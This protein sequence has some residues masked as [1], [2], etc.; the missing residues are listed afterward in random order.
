M[1]I[2]ISH[3]I[4]SKYRISLNISK[5]GYQ[6]YIH[7]S[8]SSFLERIHW[9]SAQAMAFVALVHGACEH[10]DGSE[11]E[12]WFQARRRVQRTVEMI[13]E[14]GKKNGVFFVS[15]HNVNTKLDNHIIMVSYHYHIKSLP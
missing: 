9:N 3:I 5:I 6:Y 13:R 8:I 10:G 4:D 1:V 2:F 14:M 15:D 7:S 11:A 12:V